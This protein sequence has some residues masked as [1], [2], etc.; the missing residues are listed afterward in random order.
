MLIMGRLNSL[1]SVSLKGE[2]AQTRWGALASVLCLFTK[3]KTTHETAT[4]TA[5]I[6]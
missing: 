4:A 5:P 6:R 1:Y 3:L 2:F